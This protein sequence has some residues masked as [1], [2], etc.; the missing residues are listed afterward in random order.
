MIIARAV[1]DPLG[2]DMRT[3]RDTETPEVAF[4]VLL[5]A[6]TV[7][8]DDARDVRAVA[9]LVAG[10]GKTVIGEESIDPAGEV[11][12]D[13]GRVAGIEP[14]IGDRDRHAATVEAQLMDMRERSGIGGLTGDDLGR[15]LV[16]ELH[17]RGPLDPDHGIGPRQPCDLTR[18]RDPVHE[19]P[20]AQRPGR[21]RAPERPGHRQDLDRRR[22]WTQEQLHRDLFAEI[23]GQ[24]RGQR[25]MQLVPRFVR[26]DPAD[27]SGP[28][29]RVEPHAV[30]PRD[31]RVIRHEAQQLHATFAQLIAPSGL[32]MVGE[33]E[34]EEPGDGRHR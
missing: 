26:P 12:V 16:H 24:R 30:Q 32:E 23:S 7:A 8:G 33:L 17:P 25:W 11:G 6:G 28:A 10:V 21:H 14:G 15:D 20:D 4:V 2:D 18:A 34:E 31:E 1:K 27:V 9:V 29:Q 3:G 5:S 13:V 19:G 22:P